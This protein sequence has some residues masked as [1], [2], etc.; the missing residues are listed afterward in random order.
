M[1]YKTGQT[2]TVRE[3]KHDDTLP[4]IPQQIKKM[5]YIG[6]TLL[7]YIPSQKNQL[8]PLLYT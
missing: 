4:Q 3:A 2:K 5:H 8:C 7:S 6:C 1:K